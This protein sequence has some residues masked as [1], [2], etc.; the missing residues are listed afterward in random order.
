MEVV[1]VNCEIGVI[2][3][4]FS[5]QQLLDSHWSDCIVS[6]LSLVSYCSPDT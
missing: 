1:T 3:H 4:L 6:W 5:F 2:V